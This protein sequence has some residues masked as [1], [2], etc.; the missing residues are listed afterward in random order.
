MYQVI[1]YNQSTHQTYYHPVA[2]AIDY[3]DAQYV[4]EQHL[5]PD[6]KILAITHDDIESS[7]Y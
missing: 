3:D 4:V 5:E 7:A 6:E 2:D 1:V